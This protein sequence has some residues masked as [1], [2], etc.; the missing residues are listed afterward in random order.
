MS[1]SRVSVVMCHWAQ[2]QLRSAV[3]R[4]SVR[5]LIETAPE[6][7]IVV[8]DN[9]GDVSDSVYLLSLTDE[10][11]IAC[12]IRNR[13]NL[14]FGVARNQAIAM[15]TGE[16]IVVTDNDIKFERG[17]MKECRDFL[18]RH[19]EEKILV[20]PLQI[21]RV[22]RT[23]N[24]AA[25]EPLDGWKMNT[26]AGSNCW[27]MRRRDFETIGEFEQ[28]HIAGTHWGRH[29]VKLGYKVACM[30]EPKAKD[31]AFKNGYNYRQAIENLEP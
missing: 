21:D 16:Y 29:Y 24:Y 23:R 6:A 26:M 11:K 22:H 25:G 10:K 15:T 30:P 20:T 12:Y 4:E 27:M 17:W 8:V 28:H 3:M 18:E 5:S 9:G 14:S 13:Y 19:A 1:S 7:E 31:M 2:N